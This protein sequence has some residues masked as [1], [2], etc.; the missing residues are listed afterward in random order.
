MLD[1]KSLSCVLHVQALHAE[2]ACSNGSLKRKKSVQYA[3]TFW[4]K[5]KL[6]NAD[7]WMTF[8]SCLKIITNEW[9]LWAKLQKA[10]TKKKTYVLITSCNKSTIVWIASIFCVQIAWCFV[11]STRL[12]RLKE[13]SQFMI[14]NCNKWTRNYDSYDSK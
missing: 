10:K 8:L 4:I 6:S 2:D 1:A 14:K 3:E 12:I 9:L 7:F 13:Q 11:I 5:A